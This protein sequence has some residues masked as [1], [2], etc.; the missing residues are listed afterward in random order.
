[1]IQLRRNIKKNWAEKINQKEV[2]A[3]I[4][5][6]AGH[7]N[8]GGTRQDAAGAFISPKYNHLVFAA[9]I[10]EIIT[11][12]EYL[13][14]DKSFGRRDAYTYQWEI[15]KNNLH[16]SPIMNEAVI[17][18]DKFVYFG[19]NPKE[20]PE[21]ILVFFP[22]GKRARINAKPYPRWNSKNGFYNFNERLEDTH[23]LL[24]FINSIIGEKNE[25][26]DLSYHPFY[27][28]GKKS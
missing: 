17:L 25:I 5:A 20:L 12:K 1:M 28:R 26:A 22:M 10:S 11:K 9:K 27:L 2:D 16:N 14:S 4:I 3:Y 15:E 7:S 21:N 6:I 13:E 23:E 18:S 8:D 24:E 19:K